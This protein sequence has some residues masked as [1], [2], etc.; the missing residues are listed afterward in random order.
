MRGIGGEVCVY[1][2]GG[3]GGGASAKYQNSNED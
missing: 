2:L 3:G 1:W